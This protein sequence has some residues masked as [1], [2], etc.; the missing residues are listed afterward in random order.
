MSG[1]TG[2]PSI[3]TIN[4]YSTLIPVSQLNFSLTFVFLLGGRVIYLHIG[5]GL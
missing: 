4:S 2:E 1:W 5:A 3:S